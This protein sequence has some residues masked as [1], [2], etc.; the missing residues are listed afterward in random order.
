MKEAM[1]LK[2]LNGNI[3]VKVESVGEKQTP[4]GIFIPG[5]VREDD[6]TRGKV[7]EVGNGH[8]LESGGVRSMAVTQGETVLFPRSRATKVA[9]D[10]YLLSEDSVLAVLD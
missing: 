7:I 6:H 4:G 2:P 1:K 8:P 3:I 9:E 10:M 5:N